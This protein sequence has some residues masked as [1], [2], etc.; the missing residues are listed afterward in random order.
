MRRKECVRAMTLSCHKQQV[1][2]NMFA[3][4]GRK[5]VMA[6]RSRTVEKSTSA[7]LFDPGTLDALQQHLVGAKLCHLHAPRR[8]NLSLELCTE[9][10]SRSGQEAENLL[11]PLAEWTRTEG[12]KKEQPK[13]VKAIQM[14]VSTSAI[15]PNSVC[16]PLVGTW[17]HIE[18]VLQHSIGSLSSESRWLPIC[19]A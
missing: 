12:G 4:Y 7:H 18:R 11:T 2:S 17:L 14:G 1:R 10:Q 16:Y 9:V 3:R 8:G 13:R 15:R 6:R 5:R 19:N